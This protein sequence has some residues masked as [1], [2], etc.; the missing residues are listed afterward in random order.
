MKLYKERTKLVCVQSHS[1]AYKEGKVYEVVKQPITDKLCLIGDDGLY[2]PLDKLVSKF[3]EH[4]NE[5]VV[6]LRD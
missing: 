1:N 6:S 3:K 4:K 5:R 2:D